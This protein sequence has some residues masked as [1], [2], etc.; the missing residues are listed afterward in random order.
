MFTQKAWNDTVDH[1]I[2]SGLDDRPKKEIERAA[3]IGPSNGA[4][5]RTCY[6]ENCTVT[7][8]RDVQKL[9][10]CGNCRIVRRHV[11][12]TRLERTF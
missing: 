10:K 11:G 12:K 8:G 5:Y 9:E 1:Y 7:E 6:G 4:L 2:R 3:K